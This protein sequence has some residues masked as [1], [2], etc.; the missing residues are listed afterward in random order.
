[1]VGKLSV[2]V[3]ALCAAPTVARAEGPRGAAA[4]R[5][6]SPAVRGE[7]WQGP[8]SQLAWLDAQ[9][10]LE[11]V[12][13]QTFLADFRS[14]SAGL[15]PT[16]GIGPTARVGTGLRFGFVMLGLR[17]RVASFEDPS[18]VGRWQIWT[19]DGE[20]GVRVPLARLEPHLALAGGYSSFGGFGGAVRGLQDGLDVHGVDVRLG[21]GVDY[22]MTHAISFGLDL[23]G[24]LL[25]VAR[26]GVSLRDLATAKQ[27]G[28]LDEAKAR[29]LEA[30]G[31]S[32]GAAMSLTAGL[33]VHF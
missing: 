26:P 13:L 7:P 28:T 19:L 17:G 8:M 20:L 12:T 24:E 14:V 6:E 25:A 22:W 33:G 21:G 16:S 9:T 32:I 4:P 18:S 10:G 23:N 31:S 30:S 11:A 1:L 3:L 27:I 5:R 15:L 2:A 29:I